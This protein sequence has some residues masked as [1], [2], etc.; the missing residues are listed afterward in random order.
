MWLIKRIEMD[1]R[2]TPFQQAFT[3]VGDDL[4]TE[5]EQIF[6]FVS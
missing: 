5:R 3:Q 4:D 1:A 2:R 6:G